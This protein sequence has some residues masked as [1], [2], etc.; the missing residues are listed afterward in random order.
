MQTE[1]TLHE[2]ACAG[3]RARQLSFYDEGCD[4]EFEITR[5]HG[6]GRLYEFLIE[7]RF[8]AGMRVLGLPLGGRSVLEVCCGSGMM[9][10]K[11][12]RAGAAV[13]GVD[14]SSAA[15]ARARERARRYGFAAKFFVGDAE[16]LAL[17]DGAFDV[18]AVHDGL[19]HLDRPQR[20]IREM[21]R[22]AREAVLIL[23]P[24]RAAL[25]RLAVRLGIAV[26]VEQ[27]GN[28]VKRLVP[29][30]VAGILRG[31]GYRELRWE[32]TLMYYPHQPP[33]WWRRFDRA[34]AFAGCRAAFWA[35]NLACGHWGNKLAL[36]AR[37][38]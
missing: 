22:V 29:R 28:K 13:T 2:N 7:Y 11:L 5:P 1:R 26:D 24:A 3:V 12:A 9:A 18:V 30:E 33:A 32:R 37:R 20:A 27:A 35:A 10:E 19:H 34:P 4:A 6:C 15:V 21:A 36:A 14:F 38:C 23:D 8:R 31:A 17:A 25:T 16:N